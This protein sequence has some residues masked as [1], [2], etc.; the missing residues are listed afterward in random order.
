MRKI[1][2]PAASLLLFILTV[3]CSSQQSSPSSETKPEAITSESLLQRAH[4]M[5]PALSPM[6]RMAV[7]SQLASSSVKRHRELA[8]VW[9]DE[10]FNAAS[11]IPDRNTRRSYQILVIYALSDM[12]S[13]AGLDKLAALDPPLHPGEYDFRDAAAKSVFDHF[14]RDHPDEIPRMVAVARHIGDTGGYP[15]GGVCN[16]LGQIHIRDGNVDPAS[17]EKL[18][19][20]GV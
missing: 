2:T 5:L 8:A 12:D 11:H 6:D 15:F 13:R 16:V 17:Q 9:V 20:A 18:E 3:A 4:T 7:I 1:S 14:Y 19:A 10:A